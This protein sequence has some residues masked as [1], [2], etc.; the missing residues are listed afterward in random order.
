MSQ[1]A[2]FFNR[3]S[4][5]PA[6]EYT[7]SADEFAEVFN[8]FFSDG[9]INS[10]SL[11]VY[12]SG[13]S[14]CVTSGYA[15]LAGRWYNNDTNIKLTNPTVSTVK[16]KD[17]IALKFDKD[18]REIK[19]TWLTG[20]TDT[21]PTL[22]NSD[23]IK[24]LLLANVELLAGGAI[25]SVSDRRTFSQALYTMSLEQFKKQ[26]NMFL[27]VCSSTLNQRLEQTTVN[28]EIIK[29]RG[30]HISLPM[31]LNFADSKYDSITEA[32]TKN[33]FD[34]TKI[35]NGW[36]DHHGSIESGD[37]ECFTTDFIPIADN[38]EMFAYDRNG[39]RVNYESLE[40]YRSRSA[41]G[42]IQH[43]GTPSSSW[44]NDCGAKFVRLDFEKKLINPKDLQIT[45]LPV[46]PSYYIPYKLRVKPD[47]VTKT[48][49]GMD[50]VT[51]IITLIPGMIASVV[52]ADIAISSPVAVSITLGGG[53]SQL[54]RADGEP[55]IDQLT[56]NAVDSTMTDIEITAQ[57]IIAGLQMT[58]GG[59]LT[60]KYYN[61][62]CEDLL[63]RINN[64]NN[65]SREI[66][67]THNIDNTTTQ[68][69][70]IAV[71]EAES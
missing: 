11:K 28:S 51:E 67:I 33:L 27:D 17:C 18:E 12:S 50:Y 9:I 60:V 70:A 16:R 42:L 25:K 61:K 47:A 40:F 53:N 32:G 13:N 48:K 69:E 21:Y 7:Y 24:Y 23:N 35:T 15:M 6:G 10:S 43:D 3:R 30:G 49:F 31:R 1:I 5:D 45:T 19:I 39:N 37:V 58:E 56:G 46:P 20:G 66:S 64:I 68:S 34:Y 26:F 8:T 22:T 14:I 54:F 59:T 52:E 41:T 38:S 29:A 57:D 71:E 63:R 44:I 2:R 36:L 62:N 65:G 55:L 4:T